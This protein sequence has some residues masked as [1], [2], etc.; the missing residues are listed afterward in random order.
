MNTITHTLFVHKGNNATHLVANSHFTYDG[1]KDS[2]QYDIVC[3]GT[4]EECEAEQEVI[5]IANVQAE[6]WAHRAEM[7]RDIDNEYHNQ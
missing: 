3:E 2:W 6:D 5:E 7:Q 1:F 4:L